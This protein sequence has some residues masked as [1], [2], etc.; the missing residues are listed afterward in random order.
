MTRAVR[1]TKI[2]K[3]PGQ[4]HCA[5]KPMSRKGV[6]R[7]WYSLGTSHRSVCLLCTRA[8][9]GLFR[10]IDWLIDWLPKRINQ[11]RDCASVLRSLKIGCAISRLARNFGI[12]RMRKFEI[13]KL[14][15]LRG[16]YIRANK[17]QYL[18]VLSCCL[19]CSYQ[20]QVNILFVNADNGIHCSLH[21]SILWR[22]SARSLC[23]SSSQVPGA[24][25][26]CLRT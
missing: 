14:P 6:Q 3:K 10:M 12:L 19:H 17:T 7:C 21:S 26:Q 25:L 18:H 15:R 24:G 20:P 9:C 5:R 1:A 13:A 2:N 4:S 11:F 22:L 23:C 8:P 16:T